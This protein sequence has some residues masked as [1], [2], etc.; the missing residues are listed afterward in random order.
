M[1]LLDLHVDA[2]AGQH[3]VARVP[4]RF[5]IDHRSDDAGER[6]LLQKVPVGPQVLRDRRKLHASSEPQGWCGL[7]V[8]IVSPAG[9]LTGHRHTARMMG[10]SGHRPSGK[11]FQAQRVSKRVLYTS[12]SVRD[13]KVVLYVECFVAH[14]ELN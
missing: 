6:L 11:D 7:A 3:A 9:E 4:C 10:S 14:T 5:A 2:V 1:V 13:E 8:L 12:C